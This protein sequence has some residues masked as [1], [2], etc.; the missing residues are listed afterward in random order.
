MFLTHTFASQI[1]LSDKFLQRVHAASNA[2]P[3]SQKFSVTRF[4]PGVV[5]SEAPTAFFD[6]STFGT[7]FSAEI[8]PADIPGLVLPNPG[9]PI[10]RYRITEVLNGSVVV[11]GS[12][13]LTLPGGSF[14]VLRE[15]RRLLSS[16][17]L[18]A[19]VSGTQEWFALTSDVYPTLRDS[20]IAPYLHLFGQ[21]S[22]AYLGAESKQALAIAYS[23]VSID[24]PRPSVLDELPIAQVQFK[25]LGASAVPEPGTGWM[26]LVGLCAVPAARSAARRKGR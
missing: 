2:I 23:P 11:D 6:I 16:V 20:P 12:G 7:S 13:T 18:E 19:H 3:L 1:A 10:D 14:E 26:F 15:T 22:H 5:V 8:S 9:N 24:P 21:V 4:Q 25:N 17:E